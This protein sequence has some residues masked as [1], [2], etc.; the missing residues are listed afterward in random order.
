MHLP[1]FKVI[2][3]LECQYAILPNHIDVHFAAK[4]Q[5]GLE[6]RERQRIADEIADIDGLIGNEETL[7]RIQFEFPQSTSKPIAASAQPRWTECNAQ[8]Q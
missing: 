5:H 4:G 1:E 6:K 3:C 7:R 2:V 8:L